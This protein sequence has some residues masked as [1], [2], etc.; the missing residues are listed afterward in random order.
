V[1]I[2]KVDKP[3]CQPDVVHE[4]VFELF[5]NLNATE[6]QLNFPTL[7]GS[8]KQG[9][10]SEDWK[11]PT[12]NLVPLFESIINHIPAAIVLEGTPQMQ[13]TSLD[14]S[15]YT[16]RIAIGRLLRGTLKEGMPVSLV[17]R[18]G[19]ILKSRIKELYVFEGLGRLRIPQVNAGDI[20]AI[21]GIDDFEIGDTV[22][23]FENPEALPP[24]S[25]DEPTISMLFTINNSPFFGKEGKFRDFAP[26]P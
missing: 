13:I 20:C 23:D 2:N 12:E 19:D 3:N 4:Q 7:Y 17:K 5:F 14:Y 10:M 22:A 18:N 8:S 24:I 21:F 15:S 9:W 26:Y 1:V 6:E 16:G 25:I 11:Q